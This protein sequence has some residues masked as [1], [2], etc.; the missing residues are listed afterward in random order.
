VELQDIKN[1]SKLQFHND[2][3][4]GVVFT[5]EN[6]IEIRNYSIQGGSH[7]SHIIIQDTTESLIPTRR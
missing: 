6:S 3:A 5:F 1:V 7:I 4:F 2:I